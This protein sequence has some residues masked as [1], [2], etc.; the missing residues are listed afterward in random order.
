MWEILKICTKC[1]VEKPLTEFRKRKDR[2]N[3]LWVR[4]QCK[5]CERNQQRKHDFY[6]FHN[7]AKR[8]QYVFEQSNLRRKR[9]WYWKI[10]RKTANMIKKK[11]IRPKSCPICWVEGEVIA[12]HPDYSK[13]NEISFCCK[14]CHMS[15]HRWE[16]EYYDII[17]LLAF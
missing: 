6:R 3:G 12:H 14:Q 10:H 8:R 16:I 1:W 9:K 4:S 5:V 7:D 2:P 17:D 11:N 15:I 13:R